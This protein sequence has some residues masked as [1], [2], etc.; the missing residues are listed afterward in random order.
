MLIVLGLSV[1]AVVTA[2]QYPFPASEPAVSRTWFRV[3]AVALCFLSFA[4][5]ISWTLERRRGGAIF[6]CFI[7]LTSLSMVIGFRQGGSLADLSGVP[8][9]ADAVSCA[10]LLGATT[11]AMLLGHWYLTATGM[12]L[13]PLKQ[14][15]LLF[16]AA[17]FLRTVVVG[18]LFWAGRGAEGNWTLLLLHWGGLVGPLVLAGLTW[19]ILRYRN[20]QSATGVLYAATILVFMGEMAAAL[21]ARSQAIPPGV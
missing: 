4:G 3:S 5:S 13:A 16:A 7:L 15:T 6:A 1:L 20:T 18:G 9:I 21:L 19:Q 2:D 17:A 14:Y 11:A 8:A 12:S 10:W